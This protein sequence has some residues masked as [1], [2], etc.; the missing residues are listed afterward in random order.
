VNIRG[1][2]TALALAVVLAGCGIVDDI[3]GTDASPT[4]TT[5][6]AEILV[7][8]AE[9]LDGVP[10]SF[11]FRNPDTVGVGAVDG[12]NG[13]LR[14]RLVGD[15]VGSARLTFEVLHVD[16]QH[17][18]RSDPLTRDLW[19]R[20]DMKKVDPARRERLEQFG[21]PANAK[22][23]FAG[24]ASAE[25]ISERRYRG[26]LDLT[27]VTDPG[28]SRLVD[29]DHVESLEH[30]KAASVPFEATLDSQGRLLGLRLTVP[31]GGGEPEQPGEISYSE[32]GY[33][34]DLLGP[35]EG[36]IG[37]A[38]EGIYEIING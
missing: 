38:P 11:Q 29:E 5:A 31:A 2:V 13:W 10:Y 26:T 19:T 34:P 16:G 23:L 33:K 35:F 3:T 8:A 14:I 37:P 21:D 27:K 30:D 7:K 6:A 32:H 12:R 9:S 36:K 18:V 24:I 1:S 28:A 17:L 25:Q 15:R 22:E 20:L 4:P